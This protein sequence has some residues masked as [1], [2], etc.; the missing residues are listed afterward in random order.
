MW[1]SLVTKAIVKILTLLIEGI[2]LGIGFAF[3]GWL[4]S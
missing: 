2:G 1:V 3:G 4:A